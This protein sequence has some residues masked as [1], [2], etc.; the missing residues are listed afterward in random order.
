VIAATLNAYPVY[1]RQ[2][3]AYLVALDD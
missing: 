2:V 1:I 3:S